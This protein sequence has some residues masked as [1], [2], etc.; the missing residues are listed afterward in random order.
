MG[1]AEN[2]HNTFLYTTRTPKEIQVP[3]CPSKNISKEGTANEKVQH[4]T[5]VK[6]KFQTELP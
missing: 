2:M 5:V 1:L 6:K 4:S 3:R